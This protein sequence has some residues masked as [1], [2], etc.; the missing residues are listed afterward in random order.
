MLEVPSSSLGESNYVNISSA[1]NIVLGK[2]SIFGD[3]TSHGGMPT[4]GFARQQFEDK[5]VF[6]ITEFCPEDRDRD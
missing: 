3:S 1:A 4:F 6:L 5:A 2:R